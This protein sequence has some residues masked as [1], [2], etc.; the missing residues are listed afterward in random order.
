MIWQLQSFGSSCIQP[1]GQNL[2]SKEL[3]D[4]HAMFENCYFKTMK[5]N[6]YGLELL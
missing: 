6:L 5:N 1:L 3:R 2:R 4:F